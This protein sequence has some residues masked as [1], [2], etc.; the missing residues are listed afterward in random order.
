MQFWILLPVPL[1]SPTKILVGNFNV[2]D[3][4]PPRQQAILCHQLGVLQSYSVL[5]ESTWRECQLPDRS[6]RLR[7]PSQETV[8]H[9]RRQSTVGHQGFTGANARGLDSIPGQGVKSHVPHLSL[10]L[11]DHMC[12]SEDLACLGQPNKGIF[13]KK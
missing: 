3:F 9:F 6:P 11:A 8:S 4:F 10:H 7:A 5:I 2:R 1:R 12:S 13:F